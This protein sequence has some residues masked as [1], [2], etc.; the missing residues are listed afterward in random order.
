[1][2]KMHQDTSL[3]VKD[4]HDNF[5]SLWDNGNFDVWMDRTGPDSKR[6]NT[7]GYKMPCLGSNYNNLDYIKPIKNKF[8][9]FQFNPAN[10]N[11]LKLDKNPDTELPSYY[12]NT[13]E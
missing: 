1:M 9:V 5:W 3:N 4:C 7:E 2:D 6:Y 8:E 10:Y 11:I 13:V 12:L